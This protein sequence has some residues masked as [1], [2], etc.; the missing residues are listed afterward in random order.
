MPPPVWLSF[1]HPPVDVTSVLKLK[2]LP[3]VIGNG[4]VVGKIVEHIEHMRTWI[5]A[6]TDPTFSGVEVCQ[7]RLV[8]TICV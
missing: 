2:K 5:E 8:K 3:A 6:E 4:G 7:D 1:M